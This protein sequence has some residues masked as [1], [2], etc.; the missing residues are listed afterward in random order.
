VR[1]GLSW[2]ERGY[3]RKVLIDEPVNRGIS[4]RIVPGVEGAVVRDLVRAATAS[5]GEALGCRVRY[6][7]RRLAV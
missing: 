1:D 2:G 3:F 5:A 4:G 7:A 6:W